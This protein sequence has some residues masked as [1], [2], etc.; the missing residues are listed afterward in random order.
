MQLGGWDLLAA[1]LACWVR[2]QVYVFAAM[3]E[4]HVYGALDAAAGVFRLG[5]E[6][7]GDREPAL[8]AAYVNFLVGCND[9]RSARAELSQGVLDR[10]QQAVRDKLANRDE[11][12]NVRESLSFLWQ[13][14]A[15]PWQRSTGL[16]RP[17]AREL[18]WGRRSVAQGDLLQ[19]F[20][21]V[22]TSLVSAALE[23]YRNFQRDLEVDEENILQTPISLGLQG[24]RIC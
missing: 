8:L 22:A 24:S 18:L 9:L 20:G 16:C 19:G 2:R 12:R 10:L 21:S 17:Q 13:K 1:L 3:T 15:R 6:R 5:L 4:Y 7:Y 14:W 11:S 23:E